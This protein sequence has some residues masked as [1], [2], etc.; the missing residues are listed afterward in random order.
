MTSLDDAGQQTNTEGSPQEASSGGSMYYNGPTHQR[1]FPVS[2][3]S[4]TYASTWKELSP[5]RCSQHVPL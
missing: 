2:F 1:T 4:P 3:G 5:W